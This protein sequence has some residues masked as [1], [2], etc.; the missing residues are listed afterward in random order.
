M[1]AVR[2]DALVRD[3]MTRDLVT[4]S[5]DADLA[6]VASAMARRHVHAVFVLG[7]AGRPE[8]VLSDFDMLAGEWL[9]DDKAG[10]STMKSVTA[11]ELMTS[12][13]ETIDAGATLAGAAACMRKLHLSRLLVTDEQGAAVGVISVSDLVAP[14]G[15]ERVGRRSVRDVMSYAIVT[16]T[17]DTELAAAARAMTERRSRSIVVIDK[18][19]Q[20][21]GVITGNDLLTLYESTQATTAKD[22]MRRPITCDIDLPLRDAIDLII[23]N[24]VHRVVVT[25]SSTADAAPAGI[26]STSDVIRE[27]AQEGSVWQV[28]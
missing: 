1:S 18:A 22:L 5:Q 3:L 17:P 10:L 28:R 21:V 19:G 8:G 7:E 12:P 20:A 13:I 14:L 15:R 6:S 2:S 11:G 26:L 23:S 9:G 16:C 4:C 24:E 25:D 27:M